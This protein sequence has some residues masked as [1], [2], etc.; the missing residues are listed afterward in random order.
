V[1]GNN[2]TSFAP[3]EEGTHLGVCCMLIDLG[4]QYSE[5]YKN[6]SRKVLIGWEIPDET[7][8]LDD[9]PHPRTIT[10]Q[11]TAS[12]GE[13]ANLRQ[14]LAAWRG[15]DFTGA[16]LEAFDLRNIVGK[17]C[18]INVIHKESNGKTYANIQNIM[19]LPKGMQPGKLADKPLV[20]DIDADPPE[21][22]D[23]LPKWIAERIK[24]SESYGER[25]TKPVTMQELDDSDG[26]LP[27]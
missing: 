16:E 26:E 22:V 7:I 12:L 9:G 25:I 23:S 20:Y 15:R 6:S 2:T 19:A 13:S 1:N 4:M 17:S 18:L 3:I 24:K 14:D 27:F 10:K 8:E 11:Y 5:V 21:M